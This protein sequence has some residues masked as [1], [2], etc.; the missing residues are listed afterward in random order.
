MNPSPT[1]LG[2]LALTLLASG[3]GASVTPAPSPALGDAGSVAVDVPAPTPAASTA[4]CEE[5]RAACGAA[6]QQFVRGHAAGLTGLDGARV[7]FAMRYVRDPGHGLDVAHG[8]V[9]AAA[10]VR[11]GA[12]EACVC[13]PQ[14][15]SNYPQMAAVVFTP[16]SAGETSREV[17]R[18]MFSQ[19]YATLGDEDVGFA[20]N[21]V[22]SAPEV[23]AAVAAL[24]DRT[25]ELRVRGLDAMAE[26][27]SAFAGLVAD[28]RPVAAQVVGGRVEGGAL[29]LDWIMPGRQWPT[30]RLALVIDHNGNH[31]CDDGDLGATVRLDGRRELD[32][33]TWVQGAD[34]QGV[35]RSLSLESDRER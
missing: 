15:A 35:C 32:G 34:L 12:F 17:A 29:S 25:S 5:V 4:S 2:L 7:R 3:C 11:G 33:L 20:L 13:M 31:R 26:G 19:R 8:V 14:G 30:E 6:P 27:G 28:E 10:E 9:V 24:S 16:G 21:G 18:A 1:A 22:P 23:E